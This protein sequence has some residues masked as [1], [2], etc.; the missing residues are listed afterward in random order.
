MAEEA[1]PEPVVEEV[2]FIGQLQGTLQGI[3]EKMSG[4]PFYSL[5][6]QDGEL[7]IVRVE[8]RNIKKLPFLFYIIKIKNNG[9]VLSYS[10][11]PNTSERIRRAVVLKNLASVLAMI[12][13][14]FKIDEI[15]FMQ[16]IDSTIDSLLSG[17]SDSYSML[18]NKYDSMSAEYFETKKLNQELTAANRNLTIQASQLSQDNKALQDQLNSLQTYSDEALMA[19]AQD[20]IEV[21]NS[22]IDIEEF[23]KTYKISE[24]RVEQILDKMVS[25][26]YLELKS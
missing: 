15:K 16:Y 22:S 13:P 4:L 3:K 14:M 25:L 6:L 10:I 12:S 8:S 18:F 2:E 9:L 26:G 11:I 23:A 5:N 24:P 20:W 7:D 21:H 1:E 19:M 17:M